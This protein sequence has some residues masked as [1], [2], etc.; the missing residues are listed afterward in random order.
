M[1]DTSA[2]NYEAIVKQDWEDL[3]E[4]MKFLCRSVRFTDYLRNHGVKVPDSPTEQ[5]Q[6]VDRFIK[7]HFGE[8]KGLPDKRKISTILKGFSDN[9]ISEVCKVI[10]PITI[11]SL[12][13]PGHYGY[14]KLESGRRSR[15]ELNKTIRQLAGIVAAADKSEHYPPIVLEPMKEALKLATVYRDFLDLELKKSRFKDDGTEY[16]D[17]TSRSEWNEI[18]VDVV[19]TLKGPV[20]ENID[21]TDN[22]YYSLTADLLAAIYP[23][24]WGKL[25]HNKA[26]Q[27]VNERYYST[28]RA[29]KAR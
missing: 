29:Q 4:P 14:N 25:G 21:I 27:K 3:D 13:T 24:F 19:D 26:T 23:G 1:S 9:V 5:N 8:Y 17:M 12:W 20:A 22:K 18:I 2:K 7:M 16:K 15:S 11:E 6:F 10:K 28:K